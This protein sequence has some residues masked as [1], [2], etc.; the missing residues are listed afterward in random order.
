MGAIELL[1]AVVI[2]FFIFIALVRGFQQELGTTIVI[3]LA[4]VVLFFLAPRMDKAITT[5]IA[6]QFGW[7]A[8]SE[9][10]YAVELGL[11]L[12]LFAISILGNYS[13]WGLTPSGVP[14]PKGVTR[15]GV[16]VTIG[17]A[18]GLL[19]VS[20][21]WFFLEHYHYPY[22]KS[23]KLFYPEEM[24]HFSREMAAVLSTSLTHLFGA[25]VM[26]VAVISIVLLLFLVVRK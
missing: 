18:N 16:N 25:Q 22:L 8:K 2:L 11:I 15:L 10:V 9:A 3:L 1:W 13:G 7:N 5:K 14:K 20:F 26:W 23:Y 21:V 17:A 19:V 6:P 12:V 4:S 24:S